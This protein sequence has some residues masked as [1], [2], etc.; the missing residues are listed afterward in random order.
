MDR[1][2]VDTLLRLVLD[3]L[4]QVIGG[5]LLDARHRF[6][7]LVDRNGADRHRRFSENCLTRLVDVAAGA[8]VHYRVRPV[9]HG[10]PQLAQLRADIGADRRIADV[11]VDLHARHAADGHRFERA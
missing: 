9:M 7:R 4:E 1:H 10:H 5:E 2:V 6:D 11:G 3:H 8:Q